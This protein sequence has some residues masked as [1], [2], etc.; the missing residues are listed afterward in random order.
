[1]SAVADHTMFQIRVT[2]IMIENGRILLVKQQVSS[3]DWSL[4]GGRLE[5][6]ETLEAGIQREVYEETGLETKVVKLLYL[7]DKPDA[8][9]PLLHIT[10]LLERTGGEIALPTNEYDHNPIWDVKMV[11]IAELTRYGFSERFQAL[12]AE[13]FPGGGSYQG[14]KRNIGL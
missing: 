10:F 3:R 7:C 9:P 12:A 1:M 5:H 14:L 8:D 2:G 6:G 13:E 4:P 11:P